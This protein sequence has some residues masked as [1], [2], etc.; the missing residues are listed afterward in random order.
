[1]AGV[2][3]FTGPTI[4]RTG[5][6]RQLSSDLK[7]KAHKDAASNLQHNE[8]HNYNSNSNTNANGNVYLCNIGNAPS[9]INSSNVVK[10]Y[11]QTFL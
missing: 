6:P 3:A 7:M 8:F 10:L 5:T 4:V 9:T 11:P 1:M 2:I